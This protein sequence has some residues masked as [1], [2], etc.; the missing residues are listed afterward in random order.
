M[1]EPESSATDAELAHAVGLLREGKLVAF[2]TETVYGLGGD[3]DSE[4]A[5][6][7]IYQ[8]KGRPSAHPLIVHLAPEANLADWAAEIPGPIGRL[9]EAFWP[10]PLTLVV[11]RARRVGDFVTG[12]QDTV[13]LRKP[14]HPVAIALLR[15]FAGGIAAPSANRYGRISPTRALHVREEFG[16]AT[17]Y[18]LEGGSC[19]VG[20]EST[21]VGWSEGR[22]LLLRPGQIS[23]AQLERVAGTLATATRGHLPRVPGSEVSHYAPATKTTLVDRAAL[24]EERT[25]QAGVLAR[26]PAPCGYRGPLWIRAASDPFGYGRELYANLRRLDALGCQEILV[27][28]VPYDSPWAAIRDRL[29]RAAGA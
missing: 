21:I 6:R 19:S 15:R 7:R 9:A 18:V 3:A 14:A 20:L 26:A 29:S 25:R 17:P 11:P 4:A 13:G 22:L 12:G 23:A 28:S 8:L 5:V 2:P 27:E 24:T 1:S 16:A 10:G